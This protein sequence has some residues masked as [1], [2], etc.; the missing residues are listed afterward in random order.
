MQFEYEISADEYVP[1]QVLFYRLTAGRKS[2]K[3]AV[4]WILLGLFFIF[5]AW[6]ERVLNWAPILLAGTGV[7]WIYCGIV[8]L[9]PGRHFRRAYRETGL[10]GMKYRADVNEEGFG[11]TGDLC[12]WRVRWSDVQLKAENEHVFMLYAKG[13]IFM[14]G[15]K[16]L[17]DEQQHEMRGLASLTRN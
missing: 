7:W 8:N 11:V 14:F 1:S 6:D 2:T 12:S 16:Y 9:F 17:T 10:A 5:V 15:K 3:Q 4:W 13:T